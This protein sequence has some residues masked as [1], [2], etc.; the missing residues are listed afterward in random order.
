MADLVRFRFGGGGFFVWA[1]LLVVLVP[2]KGQDSAPASPQVEAAKDASAPPPGLVAASSTS[3]EYVIGLEDV[4]SVDVYDFPELSKTVRVANDGT[5]SLPLIGD[6]PA[7]GLTTK[8]FEKELES[9]WGKT[10][11][12]NPSISV[13]VRE[14]NAHPVSVVGQVGRPGLYP[15][16]G[17]R[18]LI[19]VLSLAGGLGLNAG[20]TVLVTRKEGFGTLDQVEGMHVVAPDQVE[21][22]V[23][24]LF[25]A[26]EEGLNI[27]IKPL[28][29]V[30][31]RRADVI[32]V[33]GAVKNS[34]G[35]T[36]A[37]RESVTVLQALAL[38]GGLDSGASKKGARIIRLAANGL[39]TEIPVDL[40]KLL[41]GK[42]QDVQ[43]A[44]NDILFV[45]KSAGK[46]AAIRGTESAVAV[47]S[48]L[49]IY[50]RI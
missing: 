39:R 6:V 24:R 49:I 31:V 35:F 25:Y 9:K 43:M 46:N 44:G 23:Y 38:A 40:G 4:L 17:R 8:Q 1:L 5:V 12:E 47:I 3:L 41:K 36:L 15:L 13:S 32:Y 27:E 48:G 22:N 30:A 18:T 10:Y 11:L 16:V 37:E 50:G 21:I 34:A 33:V 45:P 29:T 20:Q 7:S 14:F 26:H 19:D 42:S 2:L 28:D